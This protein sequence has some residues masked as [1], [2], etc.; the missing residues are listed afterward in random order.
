MF[1]LLIIA[2]TDKIIDK[3]LPFNVKTTFRIYMK[4]KILGMK[5]DSHYLLD[6]LLHVHQSAVHLNQSLQFY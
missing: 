1:N 6:P 2:Y 3:H 5:N 4:I